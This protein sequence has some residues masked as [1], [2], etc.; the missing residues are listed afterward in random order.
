MPKETKNFTNSFNKTVLYKLFQHLCGN[1][2]TLEIFHY[3]TH[4]HVL[5]N[6]P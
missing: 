2:F 4:M 1:I 5:R 3:M 6:V